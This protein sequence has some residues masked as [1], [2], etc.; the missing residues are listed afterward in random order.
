MTKQLLI[1]L[2]ALIIT[3]LV[4]VGAVYAFAMGNVDGQWSH[5]EPE[6]DVWG[7]ATNDTWASGPPS[8]STDFDHPEFIYFS[9]QLQSWYGLILYDDWNQVR[10]GEP[11]GSESDFAGQSG[12]GFDGVNNVIDPLSP[13]LDSP[14]LLGKFCHFNNPIEADDEMEWVDLDI[15]VDDIQCDPVADNLTP[16]PDGIL[17]FTYRF[18]LDETT[19]NPAGVDCTGDYAFCPYA[20]G[21]DTYCPYQSGV[22]SN[23]CADRVDIGALPLTDSFT[24]F[25]DGAST[26]Y[27][28]GVLGLIPLRDPIESCPSTPS[29]DYAYSIVSRE[30]ADNCACLYGV[31]T[32]VSG[33]GVRL[34]NFSA[35]FPGVGI[36]LAWETASE[37]DNLG[38]NLYRS[39]S[40]IGMKV[41]L[42]ESMIPSQVIGSTSGAS[43]SYLNE[44]LLAAGKYYYWLES[45]DLSGSSELYE[46]VEVFSFK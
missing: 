20:N 22:N 33:T 26:E 6:I 3:S 36:E 37:V 43:Y 19:N 5:I 8:E 11:T 45:I 15:R 13:Y 35:F 28:I 29:G 18:T 23:G 38:F 16:S 44:D 7:S 31:V 24:C 34:I 40:P 12:F 2:F 10:Y 17:D 14:F 30:E 46:P 4:V 41:K 39:S 32:E 42:N 21:T 27:K 25:Y 1:I 9:Y